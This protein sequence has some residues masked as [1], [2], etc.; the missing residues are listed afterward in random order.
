MNISCLLLNYV[1]P[2]TA[3][4]HIK[5]ASLYC[6]AWLV[7]CSIYAIVTI[8]MSPGLTRGSELYLQFKTIHM[9]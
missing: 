6:I 8:P 4:K 7:T 2:K 3:C 1:R 9:H 5:A